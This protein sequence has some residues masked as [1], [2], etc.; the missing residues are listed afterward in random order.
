MDPLKC[1]LYTNKIYIVRVLVYF[2]VGMI[3]S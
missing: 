2:A 3:A 1:Q